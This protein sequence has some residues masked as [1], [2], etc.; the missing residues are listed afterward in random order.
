M[1]VVEL[2]DKDG[3]VVVRSGIMTL[4]VKADELM[5]PAPEGGKPA[6]APPP[7]TAL[8]RA[9]NAGPRPP[10]AAKGD[11][12][13]PGMELNLTGMTSDAAV[14]EVDLALNRAFS[15][16]VRAVRIIHGKGTGKLRSAVRDYLSQSPLIKEYGPGDPRDGGDGVTIA[17]I[18]ERE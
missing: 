13:I 11:P 6:E 12:A 4:R 2:A 3:V 9:Q 17:T 15:R 7:D 18:E 16:G 5:L 10:G 1:E 8:S 14:H